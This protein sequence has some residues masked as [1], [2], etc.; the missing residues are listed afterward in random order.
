MKSRLMGDLGLP[1]S[2]VLLQRRKLRSFFEPRF[3]P[4]SRSHFRSEKERAT[5]NEK[6]NENE[7]QKESPDDKCQGSFFLWRRRFVSR[8]GLFD[9]LI[10]ENFWYLW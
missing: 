2:L 3:L 5:R 7:E 9:K 10:N 6:Q 1:S 8:T 4:H